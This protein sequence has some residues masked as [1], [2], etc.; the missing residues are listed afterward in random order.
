[1]N[2]W[3]TNKPTENGYYWHRPDSGSM[4]HIVRVEADPGLTS[5]GYVVWFDGEDQALS[6]V[7][8]EWQRVKRPDGE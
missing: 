2:Y 7:A 3:T 8:G 6:E 4:A 1:M 5:L